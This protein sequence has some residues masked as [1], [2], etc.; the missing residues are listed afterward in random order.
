[1]RRCGLLAVALVMSAP[2]LAQLLAD[3]AKAEAIK[4]D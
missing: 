3:D 4:K 1:M 2:G